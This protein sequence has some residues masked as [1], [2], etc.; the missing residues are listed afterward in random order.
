MVNHLVNVVNH[1]RGKREREKGSYEWWG[2]CEKWGEEG[3]GCGFFNEEGKANIEI[4][5][6]VISGR[7]QST[8]WKLVFDFDK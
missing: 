2:V 8:V 5:L 1:D 3:D 4:T 6:L 7:N